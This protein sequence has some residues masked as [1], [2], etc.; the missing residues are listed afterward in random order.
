MVKLNHASR[1]HTSLEEFNDSLEI[2]ETK[3]SSS[4]NRFKETNLTSAV[5]LKILSKPL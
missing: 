5:F 1:K 3:F 2:H 4:C